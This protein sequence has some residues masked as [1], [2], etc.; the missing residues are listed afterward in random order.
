MVLITRNAATKTLF[1]NAK[2]E[3][4]V[5]MPLKEKHNCNFELSATTMVEE[6]EEE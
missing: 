5:P 3:E 4:K 1:V 2:Y 6:E